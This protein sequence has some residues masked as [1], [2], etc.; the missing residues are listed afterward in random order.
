MAK[1]KAPTGKRDRRR[2]HQHWLV[3]IIYPDGERFERVY[4]D[5]ERAK[6]FAARQKKSPLVKERARDSVDLPSLCWRPGSIQ[7]VTVPHRPYDRGEESFE[8]IDDFV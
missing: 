7:L 4:L 3:T 1:G 2:K 5:R 8:S 6:N